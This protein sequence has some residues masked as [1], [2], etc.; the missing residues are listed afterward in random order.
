MT[1]PEA[2][3][4]TSTARVQAEVTDMIVGMLDAYGVGDLEIG[5]QSTFHDDLEMES[6][7]LVTLAGSLASRYGAEVNLAEYLAEKDL[8]EVI[9]LTVGDVVDY[10]VSRIHRR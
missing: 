9:G 1:A 7:D 8:D 5:M 3:T 10:V 4:A 2:D 6:I